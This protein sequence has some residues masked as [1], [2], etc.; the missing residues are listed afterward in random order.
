MSESSAGQGLWQ[1]KLLQTERPCWVVST[2]QRMGAGPGPQGVA[3]AGQQGPKQD[4]GRPGQCFA[5]TATGGHKH[6]QSK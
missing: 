3:M 6:I 1:A 4:D 5:K 2:A